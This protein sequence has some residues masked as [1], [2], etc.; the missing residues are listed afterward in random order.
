VNQRDVSC[1]EGILNGDPGH[2]YLAA[3]T[4]TFRA[5]PTDQRG[6]WTVRVTLHD[7]NSGATLPLEASFTVVD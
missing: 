1:Y 6:R 3:P 4:L 2:A 7:R 5:E